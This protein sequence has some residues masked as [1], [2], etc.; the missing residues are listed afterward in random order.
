MALFDNRT[1]PITEWTYYVV[2]NLPNMRNIFRFDTPEEAIAKYKELPETDRSAI[3]A[4]LFSIH[5]LDLIHRGDDNRAILVL[6][7]QRS[8]DPVWRERPVQDAIDLMIAELHVEHQYEHMFGNRYP[9]TAIALDRYQ[10]N[11]ID[12]YFTS[13]ALHPTLPHDKD[14]NY[15]SSI[16]EVYVVGQGWLNLDQFLEHL[17]KS[18]PGF[19]G[20]ARKTVYVEQLNIK[21]TDEHGYEH[22]ADIQPREFKLLREK[23]ERVRTERKPSLECK[24]QSAE[25]AAAEQQKDNMLSL[26]REEDRS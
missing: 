25:K 19:I 2:D 26:N 3:G 15:L 12:A 5:E 4:S 13:K 17:D 20:D 18:K 10:D 1:K 7:H 22:Q 6:D 14:P 24:I 8:R 11:H 21:Y 23:A 9:S 16:N